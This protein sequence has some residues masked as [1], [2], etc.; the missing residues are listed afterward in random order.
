MSSVWEYLQRD[1]PTKGAS[2]LVGYHDLI[3]SAA[4]LFNLDA[5][6]L[7]DQRFRHVAENGCT[8]RW[9]WRDTDLYTECF[10]NQKKRF[11]RPSGLVVNPPKKHQRAEAWSNPSLIVVTALQSAVC[12]T[13]ADVTDSPVLMPIS[14]FPAEATATVLKPAK[15]SPASSAALANH[16]PFTPINLNMLESELVQHPDQAFAEF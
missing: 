9:D 16:Q 2:E 15:S 14:V 5:V 1:V 10:N 3:I 6:P 7:Y 12:S 13:V 8:L 4:F 11:F